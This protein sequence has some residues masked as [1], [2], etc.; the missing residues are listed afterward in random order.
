MTFGVALVLMGL[1]ALF[2]FILRLFW[3]LNDIPGRD[4]LGRYDQQ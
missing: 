1:A 3:R 2:A 4:D